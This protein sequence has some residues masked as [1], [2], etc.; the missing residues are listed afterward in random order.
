MN[1]KRLLTNWKV[2]FALA[3]IALS[4]FMVAPRIGP[5]GWETNIKKGF[6]LE[7]GV[8]AILS[9]ETEDRQIIGDTIEILRQRLNIY[10]LQDIKI[11]TASDLTG[12]TYI[13]VEAAGLDED[14]IRNVV[15]KQGKFEAR[16]GNSTI[17]SGDDIVVDAYRNAISPVRDYYEYYIALRMINPEASERFAVETNKLSVA[18]SD[19]TAESGYLNETLDLYI[20]GTKTSSLQISADLKGRVFD[21][22]VV[23]GAA[24]TKEEAQTRM[25]QM[26]AL[27]QSGS[28]P[29]KLELSSVEKVSPILGGALLKNVMFAGILAVLAVGIVIFIRYRSP[30]ITAIMIATVFAEALIVLGISVIIG[31]QL[32]LSAI[33]GI[34]VSLGTGINQEIIMVDEY[35]L[36]GADK[37]KLSFKEKI[38]QALFIIYAAFGTGIAAML[39]LVFIGLGAVRGFAI[40]TLIGMAGGVFITR[41]AFLAA[42][43]EYISNSPDKKGETEAE[44]PAA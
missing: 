20:D 23:Q 32:D 21:S 38:K 10:G 6:D 42:L 12:E 26:K 36:Y 19:F 2:V 30:E 34:I 29:M 41:P 4:V 24:Q 9:P 44:K 31:W 5:N 35:F 18:F 37:K 8:R 40:T 13:I 11:S 16:I 14:D 3:I 22:P 43:D 15:A 33:A 39:P 27:L 1:W 7:G 25:E 28:L 17:F